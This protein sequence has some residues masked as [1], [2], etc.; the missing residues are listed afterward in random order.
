MML[1]EQ[2]DQKITLILQEPDTA[3]FVRLVEIAGLNPST[4]FCFSNMS[5]VDFSHCDL[6]KYDFTGASIE[7][8]RFDGAQISGAIFKNVI[9][10]LESLRKAA[11]WDLYS[12]RGTAP[13]RGG[14]DAIVSFQLNSFQPTD[15]EL[16]EASEHPSI[17]D[18]IALVRAHED[19]IFSYAR[20]RAIDPL[21]LRTQLLLH[22]PRLVTA[23]NFPGERDIQRE[24]RA[25]SDFLEESQHPYAQ[26]LKQPEGT[27]ALADLEFVS[28]DAD[29]AKIYHERFHYLGSYRPG[30]HFAFRDKNSGRIVCI[31]SVASFDLKHAEEKIAPYVDPRSVFVLSRFFAFRWAPE[32]T[33]SHFHR[34]LRLQLIREFDTKLM[35]SFINPNLGFNASSHKGAHWTLFAREAGTRYMYLDGRYRTMRFFVKNYGTSDAAKLKKKLGRSFEVSTI[36]LHPMWLLAIPLQRRARKAI[37]TIPYLFQRPELCASRPENRPWV[38]PSH[39][40]RSAD[41]GDIDPRVGPKLNLD[42]SIP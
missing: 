24:I 42:L 6:R 13:E 32:N 7:G 40:P 21:T 35:F 28:L 1:A 29:I 8:A 25:I 39:P 11:D 22:L 20:Q 17:D 23:G 14:I 3:D 30:R 37:P 38:R 34:K 27:I 31:G 2:I 15:Q 16:A 9:G 19:S 10:D 33:F 5:G 26:W 12:S 4:D 36:D 18:L 41:Y